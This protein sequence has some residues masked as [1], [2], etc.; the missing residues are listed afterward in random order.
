MENSSHTNGRSEGQ[1]PGFYA[2][3]LLTGRIIRMKKAKVGLAMKEKIIRF[4]Q[5]RYGAYGAD[6]LTKFLM[7]SG[8]ILIFI[9]SAFT[10]KNTGLVCFLMGWSVIIYCYYRLISKNVTKCYAQN[11][12]FLSRTSGI[13]SLFRK[14]ISLLQQRKVYHIYRCPGCKQKIRIPRG[15]GKIEIKCPKCSTSFIKNS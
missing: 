12:A 8:L 14:Q 11:Q 2:E 13:R 6:A 7:A 1:K 9:S 15:K 3:G 10:G 4:M 5:G